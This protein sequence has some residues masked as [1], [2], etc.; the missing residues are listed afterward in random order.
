MQQSYRLKK[1]SQFKERILDQSPRFRKIYY[2]R[3]SE[4]ITYTQFQYS[5]S[6]KLH[7][8]SCAHCASINLLSF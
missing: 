2:S 8:A 3:I 4:Q 6:N 7:D 5:M 1:K